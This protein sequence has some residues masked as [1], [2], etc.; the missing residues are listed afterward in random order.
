MS[1]DDKSNVDP[2]PDQDPL[3]QPHYYDPL[4]DENGGLVID[5]KPVT[6]PLKSIEVQAQAKEQLQ[7]PNIPGLSNA[8]SWY[9]DGELLAWDPEKKRETHWTEPTLYLLPDKR[10]VL[11][12]RK[13]TLSFT[14]GRGIAEFAEPECT[15]QTNEQAEL[16]LKLNG[17][18][19][20]G[21]A[22]QGEEPAVTALL[23]SEST[24]TEKGQE[25]LSC[26]D[27]ALRYN[28]DQETL[29]GRL[30]TWMKRNEKDW[31]EVTD[32]NPREPRYLYR[33]MA[34]LPIIEKLKAKAAKM[35]GQHPAK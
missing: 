30:R 25:W 32:C 22:M 29:R 28:V 20:P 10:W 12:T 14:S 8:Q 18:S 23:T 16:K 21:A 34:V 13:M 27:L 2:T 5:S 31:K 33:V 9:L 17:H 7:D 15:F 19:L 1:I 6:R 26:A 3:M 4:M 11:V 24:S 35:S